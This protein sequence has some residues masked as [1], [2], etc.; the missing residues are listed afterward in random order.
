MED[1]IEVLSFRLE[2]TFFSIPL[3]LILEVIEIPKITKVPLSEEYIKGITNLRGKIIPIIDTKE[4]LFK[5]NSVQ[6]D[7]SRII[8]NN[9]EEQQVGFWVDTIDEVLNINKS[10]VL[11]AKEIE[12]ID[13]KNIIG[14][15][16]IK[17]KGIVSILAI[18]KMIKD[19]SSATK[20]SSRKERNKVEYQNNEKNIME[21]YGERLLIFELSKVRYAIEI[22]FIREIIRLPEINEVPNETP[23]VIGVFELRKN[24]LPLISL[25]RKLGGEEDFNIEEEDLEETEKKV[26]VFNKDSTIVG[27]LVDKILGVMTPLKTAIMPTPAT[28][29]DFS[30]KFIKNIYRDK[31][32]HIVFIVNEEELEEIEGGEIKK[33]ND[34][35]APQIEDKEIVVIFKLKDDEFSIHINQIYEIN[36]LPEI[37]NI[38]NAKSFIEGIINLR[39]DIIPVINMR[40]RLGYN[41]KEFD[42]FERVIIVD[43]DGNKTGLIVDKVDEIKTVSKSNLQDVPDYLSLNIAKDFIDSIINLEEEKRIITQL[44]PKKLLTVEEKKYLS[45]FSDKKI[46][47]TEV[48]KAENQNDNIKQKKT[49]QAQND[50]SKKKKTNKKKTVKKN[51][52]ESK[53]GNIKKNNKKLKRAR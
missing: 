38:P 7:D 15:F 36:R 48:K 23:E 4:L 32:G 30:K 42:E 8:I 26:I 37:T 43:I 46:S 40:K 21:E 20:T 1:I 41:E 25:K 16:E 6:N 51:R 45:D 2:D 18:D 35:I 12:G 22:K 53:K 29:D 10:D 39:G 24:V 5:K 49:E 3:Q 34:N 33:E 13:K 14:V 31:E 11:P 27:I 28:F 47:E 44:S 19:F 9:F 52:T 17:G 50:L